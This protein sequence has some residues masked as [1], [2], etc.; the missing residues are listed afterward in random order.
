MILQQFFF[1]KIYLFNKML[2]EIL[3]IKEL[4]KTNEKTDSYH[5]DYYK[6]Y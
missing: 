1:N 5:A 3:L 2:D 4:N 6:R